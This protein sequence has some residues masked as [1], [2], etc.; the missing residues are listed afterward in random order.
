MYFLAK[1]IGEHCERTGTRRGTRA[2]GPF[3]QAVL[4]LRWLLDA[5]R[6]R[7]LAADNRIGA[8]TEA[9]LVLLH[10]EHDRTLPSGYA[11]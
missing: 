9:A 2:L 8:I 11:K 6:V 4:A 10:L 1:L 3:R 5:T 7:R